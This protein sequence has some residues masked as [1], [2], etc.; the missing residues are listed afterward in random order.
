VVPAD[1]EPQGRAEQSLERRNSAELE[2]LPVPQGTAP[3]NPLG[4]AEVVASVRNRY[5]LL[6][7]VMQERRI[8]AGKQRS[9]WGEFD[10]QIKSFSIAT[11]EGFYQTYRNGFSLTQP[12][13]NGGYLY[14]GYKIGRGNFEPW[15]KERETNEGG[16]FSAGFGLPLLKG[17]A[18]D[19]RRSTL[20]QAELARQAA[21]PAIA[22]ELLIY[23]RA[24]SQLYWTWVAS[25]Q[26]LQA[27]QELLRLAQQR[28]RQIDRRVESGDLQR[29]ARINNQQLIASRET[30]LIEAQRKLQQSAIKLSLFLRRPD[31]RPIVPPASRLPRE[32][33]AIATIDDRDVQQDIQLA[34]AGRPELVQLRLQAEQVRVQLEEA[35]NSL[36]PKLDAVVLAA[37]DVGLPTSKKGDKTPFELEAGLY[38]E[39]PLQRREAQGKI[40]TARGKLAQLQA[41]QEFTANKVAAEVRDALSALRAAERR[42]TRARTSLRLARE[43]LELG[44]RQF[45]AGDIDVQSLN[46]FE[47]A[48]T[49]AMLQVIGAQADYFIAQ[50]AYQTAL[51]RNPLDAIANR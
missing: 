38:G 21:D 32:F 25:G 31:G 8:A 2:E 35:R 12:T 24:A 6:R 48:A 29:I 28:V 44:R 1:S 22:T 13:F 37:K 42:L 11:P 45:N 51:A 14:S 20:F 36:L 18:I 10:L 5:P 49:D 41:K 40:E 16:E 33:P 34:L 30:K 19:E 3:A 7:A 27:Q 26:A 4:L 17:R 9:A 50:A 46:L 23:L 47:Q 43:T 15:F 39:L